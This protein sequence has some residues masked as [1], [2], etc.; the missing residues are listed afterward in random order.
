MPGNNVVDIGK[1]E[2]DFH[3]PDHIKRAGHAASDKGRTW[4]WFSIAR[5]PS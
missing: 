4:N 2:P 5:P 3:T 1:G